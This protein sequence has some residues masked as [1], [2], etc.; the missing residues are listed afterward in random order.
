MGGEVLMVVRK[1]LLLVGLHPFVMRLFLLLFR[2]LL[3]EILLPL[4]TLL[5]DVVRI[6]LLVFL[7]G[8]FLLRVLWLVVLPVVV[9]MLMTEPEELL[10]GS[11]LTIVNF[12]VDS[13]S[14]L[15]QGKSGTQSSVLMKTS[16]QSI[17]G[18]LFS[19][20]LLLFKL[21]G[22]VVGTLLLEKLPVRD[23]VDPPVVWG[24]GEGRPSR[25]FATEATRDAMLVLSES[26]A[27][28]WSA[29]MADDRNSDRSL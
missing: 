8:E 24:V 7:P 29:L 5:N 28:E 10:I 2:M 22:I 3:G 20:L 15:C 17:G 23:I 1:E 16:L 27:M 13:G 11:V 4:F 21:T 14:M 18:L 19:M 9:T 6:S 25:E 12:G 26:A